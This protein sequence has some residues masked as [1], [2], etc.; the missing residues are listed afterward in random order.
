MMNILFVNRGLGMFRGGGETYTLNLARNLSDMGHKISFLLGRPLY[1]KLKHPL[2]EFQTDYVIS[3]YLRDYS[4]QISNLFFTKKTKTVSGYIGAKL[5]KIDMVLFQRAALKWLNKRKT[6]FDIVQV[7][8]HPA[9]AGKITQE[10]NIPT[11]VFFPGPPQ[12]RNKNS[13]MNCSAVTTDGYAIDKLC[14]IRDDA[15]KIPIGIDTNRFKRVENKIRQKYNINKNEVVFIFVGRFVP[16]KNLPFLLRSFSKLYKNNNNVRLMLIGIGPLYK[17]IQRLSV[18]FGINDK[19]VFTGS[20]NNEKLSE[21]YSAAD[22]F[23][24]TSFYDNSPNVIL[25]SMSCGL[26]VIATM[27]GGI[28]SLVNNGKNGILVQ[29]DN[30]NEL[31]EAMKKLSEDE[32][33]RFKMGETSRKICLKKYNWH[34]TAVLYNDLYKKVLRDL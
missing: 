25:E 26:P 14:K 22:V 3:P 24:L 23:V 33:L 18:Q 32:K 27:V 1:A 17:Q 6:C 20:V 13:I 31:V 16:L 11:V 30:T 34:Q 29:T 7:L 10:F 12:D 2:S 8:S 15:C 5:L 4:Q 19:V 21:Y 28:P 9:L